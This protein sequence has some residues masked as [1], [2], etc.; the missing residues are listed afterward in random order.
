MGSFN[1]AQLTHAFND[2]QIQPRLK[3]FEDMI[4][5]NYD[6]TRIGWD[7]KWQ[8]THLFPVK[9]LSPLGRLSLSAALTCACSESECLSDIGGLSVR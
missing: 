3:W 6:W 1:I 4:M 2:R 8:N 7:A 9:R 5:V